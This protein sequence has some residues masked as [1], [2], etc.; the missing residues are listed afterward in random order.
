[1]KIKLPKNWLEKTIKSLPKEKRKLE[2][3]LKKKFKQ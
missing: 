3:I 2:N 1:M